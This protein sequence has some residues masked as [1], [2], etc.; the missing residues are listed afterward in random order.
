[1]GNCFTSNQVIVSRDEIKHHHEQ[2]IEAGRS[3]PTQGRQVESSE[4]RKMVRF[5]LRDE[6]KKDNGGGCGGGGGMRI[7]VVVTKEELKQI[8]SH[9]N[10]DFKFS[11]MEQL[12]RVVRLRE[13][14]IHEAEGINGSWKPALESIPEDH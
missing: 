7:R 11:S 12:A 10:K 8:L 9:K 2:Q 4:K 13:M 6:D 3:F 5:K 1:M 14:R